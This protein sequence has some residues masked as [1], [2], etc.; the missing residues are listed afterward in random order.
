[1]KILFVA[2]RIPIPATAGNRARI[3]SLIRTLGEW[4]HEIHY[5]FVDP[6]N[7]SSTDVAELESHLSGGKFHW[8][9]G[10]PPG[11]LDPI[12]ART[13]RKLLRRLKHEAGYRVP[14]DHGYDPRTT[15]ELARLHERHGF[16]VVFIEYV[17]MSKAAEAFSAPTVRVLDT[18]DAFGDRHKV[19]LKAGQQPSWYATTL[20]E[21]E[22]GFRRA[23]VVVA[24][25]EEEAERFRQRLGTDGSRVRTVGHIVDLS[26]RVAPTDLPCAVFVGSVN[27]VNLAALDFLTG[28]VV[29]R[30]RRQRPDF[31]LLVAGP[32]SSKVT[33]SEAV[34][35]CGVVDRVSDL[36]ARAS[37]SLNPMLFGT[38]ASIKL[39]DAMACGVPTVT[40][41][42]GARGLD[43][44]FR[45]GVLTAPSADP[46]VFAAA[47][48]RLLGDAE[49]R[50]SLAEKAFADAKAWNEEQRR[51][52][53]E[54]IELGRVTPRETKSRSLAPK[55]SA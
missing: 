12:A 13:W 48:L 51:A 20:R 22:R 2:N 52:L 1:M 11:E 24:I 41:E 39:L 16:D 35:A 27:A 29:P 54:I 6:S 5:A 40:T 21:E 17:F 33:P 43:E 4:G 7:I 15:G 19:F 31:R 23:D 10:R 42:I 26:R 25:Q 37:I 50:H 47:I 14:L 53:S 55:P 18:H 8:I 32:V 36:F 38:G 9:E 34:Q 45:N 46:E 49:F 28:E 30:V 44:R 3:L